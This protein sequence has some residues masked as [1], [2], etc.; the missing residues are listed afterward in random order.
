MTIK[1]GDTIPSMKLMMAT[2]GGAEGDLH[3]RDLQGQE[4]G[5]VRGSR[6]LHADL[7]RQAPAGLRA[8]RRRAARPRA[9][10]PSPAWR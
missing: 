7:Q 4:G 6:R 5:A 1:V 2:A 10:T 3:R 8:E 9:S